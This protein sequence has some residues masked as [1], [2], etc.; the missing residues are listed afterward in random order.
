VQW[1]LWAALLTMALLV[2]GFFGNAWLHRVYRNR[3]DRA[4]ARTTSLNDA[5]MLL[6]RQSSSRPR[7]PAI[8]LGNLALAALVAIG[9]WPSELHVRMWP[10]VSGDIAGVASPASATAPP[11][12]PSSEAATPTAALEA[13]SPIAVPEP[14]PA[15]AASPEAATPL[16]AP[17]PVA[18]APA[19]AP[20]PATA[21]ASAPVIDKASTPPTAQPG[22]YLINVG[23]FAQQD[24]ALRA[25]ATL[26]AAGLPALSESLQT[27]NGQ[28]TRVR[29]GPFATRAQAD[30]AAEQIRSLQ[31]E[32]VVI[33]P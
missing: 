24:N 15:T 27:R 16:E 3:L 8:A 10:R 20:A 17:A 6:A 12:A 23:L 4:L 14:A 1:S 5:C 22:R 13:A 31:L 30:A 21:A 9:S 19:T 29:V 2:P 32:A 25:H 11:M 7:L 18:A 28:R 26:Q 33:R